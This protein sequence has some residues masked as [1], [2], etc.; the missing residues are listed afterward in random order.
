MPVE[1]KPRQQFLALLSWEAL[2]YEYHEKTTDWY[3]AVGIVTFG[4]F[5]LA[6]IL[7]NFLFAILVAIAGFTFA[8]Y[9]ARRP[10]IVSFAITSR[11]LKIGEKLYPYD[12][13]KSFWLNYDPPNIKELYVISKKFFAPQISIPLGASDPNKI[14][15]YLLKFLEEKEIQ[16]SLSDV[17]ARFFRF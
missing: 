17:I 7:K 8:L 15:E 2:E 14:R 16:E 3:W 1:E 6:L 9:G 11:G 10:K 13:L 4:F 5:V 12:N